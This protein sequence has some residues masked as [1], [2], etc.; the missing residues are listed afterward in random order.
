MGSRSRSTSDEWA[1]RI[2][3]VPAYT[4]SIELAE[5]RLES[6][7]QLDEL[8]IALELRGGIHVGHAAAARHAG[9][10]REFMTLRL[11]VRH[12]PIEIPGRAAP[13][14]ESVTLLLD[15][16]AIHRWFFIIG[17][18]EFDIHMSRE[19]HG[20]RYIGFGIPAA[21]LGIGAAEMIEQEPR[22]HLELVDPQAH[23]RANIGH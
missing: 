13:V 16:L 3:S 17:L 19:A 9:D 23:G 12:V 10:E 22:S 14:M 18:D 8:H 21:V 2:R 7:T 4:G 11:I 1:H 5:K 6:R 20:E 15:P